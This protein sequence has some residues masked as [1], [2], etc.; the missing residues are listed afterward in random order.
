M[1]VYYRG[2]DRSGTVYPAN[3]AA[4]EWHCGGW[5]G[6][7]CG[8]RKVGRGR[9]V[10]AAGRGVVGAMV[11]GA[12][13]EF[14]DR[15]GGTKLRRVYNDEEEDTMSGTG[16]TRQ[17]GVED[18]EGGGCVEDAESGVEDAE[19]GVKDAAGSVEDAEGH[20]GVEELLKGSRRA[21]DLRVEVAWRTLRVAWRTLRVAWRTLR[22]AWRTLRVT[23]AWRSC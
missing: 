10:G 4:Q 5:N 18:A 21:G 15:R 8:I 14:Q 16:E 6:G 12:M 2:L 9:V 23:V 7:V 17:R 11:A 1:E 3:A 19:D 22:V 13:S 20:S